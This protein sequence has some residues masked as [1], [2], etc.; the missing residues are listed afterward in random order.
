MTKTFLIIEDAPKSK[1]SLAHFLE[2]NNYHIFDTLK[3]DE[4]RDRLASKSLAPQKVKAHFLEDICQ[5]ALSIWSRQ[6][7]TANAQN[8]EAIDSMTQRFSQL[9]K[10]LGNAVSASQHSGESGRDD[11]LQVIAK[12]QEELSSLIVI[13][14]SIQQGR[15]EIVAKVKGLS[16]H[17]LELT[18]MANQMANIALQT[19]LL[20]LNAAI[21]AAHSGKHGRGF[22]VV[23]TEV[24][25]LSVY[26]EDTGKRMMKNIDTINA[27]I[28]KTSALSIELSKKDAAAVNLADTTVNQVV[29]DFNGVAGRLVESSNQLQNASSHICDE[30]ADVLVS[31]RFEDKISR[32]LSDVCADLSKLNALLLDDKPHHLDAQNWIDSMTSTQNIRRS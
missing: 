2:Q 23:S 20:A 13:L 10:E 25:K 14:E 30:I 12:S 5:G 31:L 17:T 21:E 1:L 8:H 9:V 3:E 15:E 4:A 29:S 24:R 18:D 28:K 6:I 11:I 32:I 7:E 27:S 22:A 26:A 16:V 19:N